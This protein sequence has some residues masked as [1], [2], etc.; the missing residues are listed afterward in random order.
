[1]TVLMA[2]AKRL[3]APA[4]MDRNLESTLQCLHV[5]VCKAVNVLQ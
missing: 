2:G 1:M 4:A 5:R 3:K